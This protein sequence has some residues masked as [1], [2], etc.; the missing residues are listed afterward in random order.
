M[1]ETEW[2]RLTELAAH[3]GTSRQGTYNAYLKGYSFKG[4][5]YVC[6]TT[7]GA[8]RPRYRL[9][10]GKP[11]AIG[12]PRIARPVGLSAALE[13]MGVAGVALKLGCSTRTVARWRREMESEPEEP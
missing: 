2:M 7:D 13:E 8:G 1:S 4:Q 12:R 10:E 6:R 5:G 3:M 11:R 9:V